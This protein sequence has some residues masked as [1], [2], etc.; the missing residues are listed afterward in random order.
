M[1]KHPYTHLATYPS[2]CALCAGTIS[3]ARFSTHH[4]DLL[5]AASMDCPGVGGFAA[6]CANGSG[7][8]FLCDI[9]GVCTADAWDGVFCASQHSRRFPTG[10]STALG[11]FGALSGGATEFRCQADTRD[12]PGFGTSR[13]SA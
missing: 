4:V 3:P 8:S 6:V 7:G 12:S 9:Y 2:C 11:V 13:V 5:P 10:F 1:K